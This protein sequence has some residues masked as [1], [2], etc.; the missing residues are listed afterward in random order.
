MS[1][2]RCVSSWRWSLSLFLWCC[3]L[4]SFCWS[5]SFTAGSRTDRMYITPSLPLCLSLFISNSVCVH[6]L[7]V[8]LSVTD[9]KVKMR[10]YKMI[11]I[12]DVRNVT[13]WVSFCVSLSISLCVSVCLCVYLCVCLS[14]YVCVCLCRP[15]QV[16]VKTVS[17]KLTLFFVVH[18]VST[19]SPTIAS[20]KPF[21][22]DEWP[23]DPVSL[24]T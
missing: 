7:S 1:V 8:C 20:V 17:N 18:T 9:S 10:S 14:V 22:P 3:C 12:V 24:V 4:E 2:C 11:Y 19:P 16:S 21:C 5:L 13:G 23:T 6:Q 15:C